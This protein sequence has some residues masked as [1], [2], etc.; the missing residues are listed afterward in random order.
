MIVRGG[1]IGRQ[2]NARTSLYPFCE[3]RRVARCFNRKISHCP[4]RS[5]NRY[6]L[7]CLS[8]LT[9]GVKSAGDIRRITYNPRRHTRFQAGCSVCDGCNTIA[10]ASVKFSVSSGSVSPYKSTRQGREFLPFR[11]HT[12][13]FP[14]NVSYVY[15]TE[16][17]RRRQNTLLL[18]LCSSFVE[19]LNRG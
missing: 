18:S 17:Y 19:E 13:S 6:E 10:V 14:E 11:Q 7:C 2:G 9:R 12:T 16:T 4:Q 3:F 8:R 15:N 5:S 1:W